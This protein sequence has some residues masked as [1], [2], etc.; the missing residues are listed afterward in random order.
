MATPGPV[1]MILAVYL[2]FV[3]KIG[4]A[5]MVKREPYKLTSGLVVYNSLQVILS[6]YMVSRV[7]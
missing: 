5:L 4:P 3:L 2:L 1:L 7:S 6:A